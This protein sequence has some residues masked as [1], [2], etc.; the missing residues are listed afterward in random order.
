MS[1][2]KNVLIVGGTGFIGRYLISELLAHSHII[3]VVDLVQPEW[4]PN[5]V[6]FIQASFTEKS[7][8]LARAFEGIDVVY[9][10]ASTTLPKSSNENIQFDIESNL[11]GSVNL[12]QY[13]VDSKVDKFIFASSGGTVY[14]NC[15]SLNI[16]ESDPTNPISSYGIVKL[17]VEKYLNL[18]SHQYGISTCS[19]RISNPYG[20]LQDLNKAQGII[21]IFMRKIKN[22]EP[23]EIWGDG[24]I[25]RDFIYIDDLVNAMRKCL[26]VDFDSDVINISSGE[27]ISINRIIELIENVLGC[28]A[29]VKYKG[30]RE[31]DVRYT[32]LDNNRAK[33]LL[34]WTTQTSVEEGLVKIVRELVV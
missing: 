30:A 33:L 7:D 10:L 1:S 8:K 26:E 15:T 29:S 21:P 13:S 16:S 25:S 9:H 31:E 22:G 18:F 20:A 11:I 27:A 3:R 24:S 28:P 6:D 23:I 4:L 12:L 14:G 32:C 19:L 5:S 34:N 2:V 17:A